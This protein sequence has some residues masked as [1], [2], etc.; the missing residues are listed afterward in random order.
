MEEQIEE[1]AR[2]IE[3]ISSQRQQL[4]KLLRGEQC[5]LEQMLEQ[6]LYYKVEP[7]NVEGKVAAVDCGIVGEE[8]HGFDFLVSRTVGVVFEYRQSKPA[9]HWYFPSASPPLKYDIRGG[10]ENYEIAWHK[11]LFR[12]K[13][14][15]LCAVDLIAK[16]KPDYLFLDG[17]IAP[18][19]S[20]K[21]SEDSQMQP[22]YQEVIGLYKLLYKSCAESNCTLCGIIKDSRS[23]RFVEIISK[24]PKVE[25]KLNSTAD[26]NFLFFLLE[27][28][29]R[30]CAFEYSSCKH[31]VLKD[32]GEWADKIISFYIKPVEND[33]PLRVEFLANSRPFSEIASFVQTL[34][35]LH[36]SYA[37][38]AILIEADLRAALSYE[39]VE[40][41]YGALFS[42]LKGT[43][44]LWKLRRNMRPFR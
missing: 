36:Q 28:K 11:G 42:R 30:T 37:Y 21:P 35:C 32:L 15:I 13:N 17:S 3:T 1:I 16:H 18:L 7:A 4:A 38:P 29:E 34:S 25:G 12:L 40:R 26:S 10:L 14:E 44:E 31:H 22:L 24:H 41:A 23:K 9:K 8:F 19:I 2:Q 5:C 33:R 39:E 20:D 6:Q 43:P 27:Q